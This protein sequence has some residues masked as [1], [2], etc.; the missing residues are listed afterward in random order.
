MRNKLIGG[1]VAVV[2]GA[3]SGWAMPGLDALERTLADWRLGC[4]A[5]LAWFGWDER[6]LAAF[7]AGRLAS[8][9]F[10]TELARR[11]ETWWVLVTVTMKGTGR[12]V[13]VLPGYPPADRDG[14]FSRGVFLGRIPRTATGEVDPRYAAPEQVVPLA[15]NAP[16]TVRI[17]VHPPSPQEGDTV[18][19][20]AEA[21]DPDGTV[22]QAWWDFG[23][24]ET[25]TSW[26]PDHA[27]KG[28]GTYTVTLTVVDNRGAV[29]TATA[30]VEVVRP[31]PV[32]PRGC[33][34]RG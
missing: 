29:A 30:R 24:G 20:I 26:S 28:E 14:Q 16:P 6:D 34:C 23:D 11:G 13:P 5:C 3:G 25:S 4:G 1:L 31:V 33:P 18:W 9:G 15:P 8:L 27:Y 22:V 7:V 17:R 21:A 19:F 10:P 2:V 12:R 32:P